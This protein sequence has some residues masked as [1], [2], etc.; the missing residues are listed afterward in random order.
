MIGVTRQGV[1]AALSAAAVG[2]LCMPAVGAVPV[3]KR[4]G[5]I[6]NVRDAEDL[7]QLPGTDWVIASG[8]KVA[9]TDRPGHLYLINATTGTSEVVYPDAKS[10]RPTHELGAGCGGAPDPR[11]F[12]AHGL[13]LRT[14]LNKTSQLLVVS[15]AFPSGGREAIELFRIDAS[16]GKPV[17]SWSDCARMPAGT[18]AND[19]VA[20]RKVVSRP[21]TSWIPATGTPLANSRT[22]RTP[23][24]SSSGTGM[25]ASK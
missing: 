14:G 2:L 19:V 3:A 15:H 9:S 10:S 12:E 24:T 8:R 16:G 20:Y 5:Y 18:W 21:P 7:V 4:I 13:G 11:N 17:I 22:A 25:P 23:A 1:R 6:D